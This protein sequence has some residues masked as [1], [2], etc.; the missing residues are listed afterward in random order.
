MH[1]TPGGLVTTVYG[2]DHVVY[3]YKNI[4]KYGL[5]SY[6]YV[7][8]HWEIPLVVAIDKNNYI[9]MLINNKLGWA[10]SRHFKCI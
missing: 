9:M 7:I 2:L 1:L 3:M 4:G 8:R 10:H 6:T 5:T